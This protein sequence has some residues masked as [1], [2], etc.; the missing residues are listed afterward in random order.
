MIS[1]GEPTLHIDRRA[2]KTDGESAQDPP[3]RK[4]SM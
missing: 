1:C 3:G 2:E 4:A